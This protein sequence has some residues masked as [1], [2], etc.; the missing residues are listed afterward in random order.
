[1]GVKVARRN[2]CVTD[3]SESNVD[4]FIVITLL[5]GLP[6]AGLQVQ[7]VAN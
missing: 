5:E 3:T 4:L 7:V 1:M 6:W 2:S